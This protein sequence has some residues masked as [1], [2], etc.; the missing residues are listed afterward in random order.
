MGIR[1][2]RAMRIVGSAAALGLGCHRDDDDRAEGEPL[3]Q[4]AGRV[5]AQRIV[6]RRVPM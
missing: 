6:E 3:R 5:A 2:S 1:W 4:P